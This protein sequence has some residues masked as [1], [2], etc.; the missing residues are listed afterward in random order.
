MTIKAIT[1]A[2]LQQLAAGITPAYLQRFTK[3][4]L[5]QELA[6]RLLFAEHIINDASYK[7]GMTDEEK[8]DEMEKELDRYEE[9]KEC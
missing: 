2:D 3:D 5:L 8:V 7:Y 4:E 1:T 9:E 6:N